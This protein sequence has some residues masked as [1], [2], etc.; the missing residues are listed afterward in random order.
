MGGT[1]AVVGVLQ[2]HVSQGGAPLSPLVTGYTLVMAILLFSWCRADASARGIAVPSAAPIL[3]ALLAIVGVPY[4]YFR[5]LP[6]G[7]ALSAIGKS[8]LF[9]LLLIVL[10]GVCS[11]VSARTSPSLSSVATNMHLSK[12]VPN[13]VAVDTRYGAPRPAR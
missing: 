2:P 8:V 6:F 5:V 4:Y 3:V 1:S 10:Q 11:F 7:R 13:R 12:S 9:F